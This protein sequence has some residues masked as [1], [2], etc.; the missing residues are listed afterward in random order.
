M[1]RFALRLPSRPRTFTAFAALGVLTMAALLAAPAVASAGEPA[2]DGLQQN[3][4]YDLRDLSTQ[5]GIHALYLRIESAAQ[6]VCPGYDSISPEVIAASKEC[7]RRAIARAIG[8]IG[9]ARL[10]AVDA[11]R[12]AAAASRG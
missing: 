9:S 6:D 5:R 3:V 11:R 4:Y 8:Q 1:S 10:A 7:Q 2:A 12:V